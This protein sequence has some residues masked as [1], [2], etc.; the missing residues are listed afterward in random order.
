MLAPLP[1]LCGPVQKLAER[2]TLADGKN[3]FPGDDRGTRT[4]LGDQSQELQPL[5]RVTGELGVRQDP[6][7]GPQVH[8]RREIAHLSNDCR[9]PVRVREAD[10]RNAGLRRP[11]E[12]LGTRQYQAAPS[13]KGDGSDAGT[14]ATRNRLRTNG[15]QIE[16]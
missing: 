7:V 11:L 12:C 6:G 14:D 15:G 16:A 2:F 10:D 4:C 1:E 5:V 3:I 13:L 8:G 9:R